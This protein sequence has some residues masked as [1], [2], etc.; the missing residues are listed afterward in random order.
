VAEL[1]DSHNMVPQQSQP[2]EPTTDSVSANLQIES[3]GGKSEML[4]RWTRISK[5][6]TLKDE[7]RGLMRSS[8]AGPVSEV[9]A[10]GK[11]E[12]EKCILDQVSGSALP[13]T[14]TALIGP[15]GSGKTTL[16][17]ILSGRTKFT[18]G[19]LIVNGQ[20]I[21]ASD[22][23][24]KRFVS[25]MAYV[26]QEDIFFDH[27]LVRDQLAYTAFLRLPQRW[28]RN[29]K[30][31]EVDRII[32]LLRLTKVQNSAINK[33]SGGERK[34]VNIGTELLTNPS[35]VL[36]DEPT[37]GLDSTNAVA[38]VKL[39][40]NLAQTQR[41]T[42]LMSI[43]QPSSGMFLDFDSLSLMAEGNIV[44][45]GSPSASLQYLRE[46]NFP[47]PP[48][49][50][51]ADH[52]MDLL[53]SDIDTNVV[54]QSSESTKNLSDAENGHKETM[55]LRKR[56][57]Q[58][59]DEEVPTLHSCTRK[60]LIEAWDGEIVA[61]ENERAQGPTLAFAESTDGPTLYSVD[62]LTQY[63]VLVHRAMK[64][65]RSAIFT[66]LNLTKS[67]AI[68][69]IS[70]L[71]WFQLEYT[72]RTVFDRT[73]YFFFTMT[74]WVFDS[75]FGALLAFPSERQVIL[76]VRFHHSEELCF[77]Y[78]HSCHPVRNDPAS[79]TISLHTS[80]PRPQAK[81]RLG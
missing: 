58:G 51:V 33:L 62:W 19:E 70:G 81:L 3:T 57:S 77:D 46:R 52:W 50:N 44:F 32:R 2:V 54:D 74:Y 6:V 66:P 7:Q 31:Q 24:S 8:I 42:I 22:G 23:S 35:C 28:P 79:H 75:M 72:E 40:K 41:K 73:S 39:L 10:R 26:R 11:R 78:F 1:N 47:C 17:N 56:S 49:Y 9:S 15:S 60:S 37:S 18:S 20:S 21:R 25:N 4:L 13:G 45:F 59:P 34:R 36:L 63:K 5:A 76:K 64:N 30:L 43:H 68:G 38:L 55:K 16:L 48:G 12:T 67:A 27:L 71:L 14:V 61:E 80:L 69:V 29:R 65:S 53:V